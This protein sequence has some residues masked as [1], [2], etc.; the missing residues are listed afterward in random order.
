[1]KLLKVSVPSGY[2]MLTK[3]FEIDFLAKA[4][5]DKD[6]PDNELLELEEDFYYP[7]ETVFIGKNSSGKTTTLSLIQ[8]VYAFMRSG[9]IYNNFIDNEN[10]FELSVVYYHDGVIYDYYGK[11]KKDTK[12]NDEFLII[13]EESLKWAKMKQS[14]KKDLSNATF[15]AAP[16]FS[17]NIGGDTSNII[18]FQSRND[19]NL[20][21]DV[22]GY[23]T[24]FFD[25]YYS[26]LK[27]K[28]FRSL[29][30]LFDDS[31]DYIR[32]HREDDKLVGYEFKRVG[33]SSPI[34]VKNDYLESVLSAG[35]LR[36]INLYG[37]SILTFKAGGTIMVDEIEKSFNR[38]LIE[39]LFIMFEDK[40]INT[41]KASIIYTTHYS[42]LL[43]KNNRCDNINVLH[44]HDNEITLMNMRADYKYRTDMLKSGQFNQNV[45]DTLINYERLMDLKEAIRHGE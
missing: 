26:I 42:E 28:T 4:R 41:A 44:R 45:F 8:N 37:A 32:P 21:I 39:N 36:G 12:A 22:L 38:N 7:V 14:L 3:N 33:N 2:K 17:P 9:R 23:S 1:M 11:F 19:F 20:S 27:E 10:Q 40:T 15:F 29:L 31:I 25:L 35:T 34:I 16:T 18:K 24:S 5:V 6:N 30:R 43:D 13:E